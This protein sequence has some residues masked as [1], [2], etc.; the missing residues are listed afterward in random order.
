VRATEGMIAAWEALRARPLALLLVASA[1]LKIVYV[2]GF[3]AYPSYLFSDFGGYWQRAHARMAGDEFGY[4]Q[5]AFWPPLPHILLAWYLSAARAVGLAAHELQAA[6]V[7]NVAASTACVALLYG[8]VLE[9]LKARAWALGVAA[10]YAF[11]FPLIYFNAFVMSEHGATLFMLAA[12]WLVLRYRS[13]A[14]VLLAAGGL[15]ALATAMRPGMGVLGL[16]AALYLAFAEG[17]GSRPAVV[18]AAAFSLGFFLVVAGALAEMHRISAGRVSGLSANGPLNFYI[19]QCRTA[20]VNMTYQGQRSSF[21]S[22]SYVAHPENGVVY[23]DFG[24]YGRRELSELAWRCLRE[25]PDRA[26]VLLGRAADLFFGPLLPTVHTAAGLSEMLPPLR[27]FFLACAIVLPLGFA[28]RASHGVSIPALRLIGGLLGMSLVVLAAYGNEHRYLYPLLPL[29]YVVDAAVVLA[30]LRDPPRFHAAG[31]ALAAVLVVLGVAAF[32]VEAASRS[33]LPPI[34]SEVRGEEFPSWRLDAP[35]TRRLVP[36]AGERTVRTTHSTCM[37][38]RVPGEY[39]FQVVVPAGFAL[40][41]DRQ[42]I[43]SEP[44]SKP[45]DIYRW[46]V[47]VAPGKHRYL[48]VVDQPV[49]A[50]ATWRRI[51]SRFNDFA[52]ALGVRHVGEAGDDAVFLPPDRC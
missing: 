4:W 43:L 5:W 16:P 20:T 14:W 1:T 32:A 25:E 22:P 18:R 23:L 11:T 15:L 45:G 52:P 9:T 33:G 36:P 42:R 49:G 44:D 12:L 35:G 27:A 39:E 38:V 48:L 2:F 50:T 46:R 13:Q 31:G 37:D 41:L 3:T 19:A 24:D 8:I 40:F 26:R 17:R 10:L 30:A 47:P 29:V 7:L 6:L 34:R 51:A 21:T 28:V